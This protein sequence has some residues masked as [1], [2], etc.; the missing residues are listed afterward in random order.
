LLS[1]QAA[2]GEYEWALK[3]VRACQGEVKKWVL[4]AGQQLEIS[5]FEREKIS[6]RLRNDLPE[7]SADY[8]SQICKPL[9]WTDKR[10]SPEVESTQPQISSSAEMETSG[11]EARRY[12]NENKPYLDHLERKIDFLRDVQRRLASKPFMSQLDKR[13]YE[14]Y[15]FLAD[16]AEKLAR[17]AWDN[18]QTIPV[19][20]QFYLAEI[21]A[22][23]TIKH[24]ACEYV[25]KVKELFALS[26]KQVT[27]TLRG[28]V[29]D[30][31]YLYEPTNKMEALMDGFYGK[32]C[33]KCKSWRVIWDNGMCR[34]C[35][36]E[37]ESRAIAEKLPLSRIRPEWTN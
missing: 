14:E 19:A 20:T 16:S 27:K 24:G 12:V 35:R 5:G 22:I 6:A 26:S 4:Y 23:S 15:A 30:I 28:V 34:C 3:Q 31:H 11:T 8:I 7:L 21:V 29:H 32:P 36:C 9:G 33:Q 13:Q 10:F 1:N 25:S 2:L 18:R 37:T 17:Q